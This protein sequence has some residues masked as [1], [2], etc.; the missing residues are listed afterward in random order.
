MG[1]KQAKKLSISEL[2]ALASA[3]P[4]EAKRRGRSRE[5]RTKPDSR[6]PSFSRSPSG[7]SFDSHGP[8]MNV[9]EVFGALRSCRSIDD[10]VT[11]IT[12]FENGVLP[13]FCGWAKEAYEA[14]ER[15][16]TRAKDAKK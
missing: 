13:E 7:C 12:L 9:T 11:S 1:R 3:N 4:P 14:L 6:S 10:V 5:R 2:K 15:K 8:P 16:R